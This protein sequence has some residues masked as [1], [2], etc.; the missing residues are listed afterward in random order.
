MFNKG[1]KV[2]LNKKVITMESLLNS[3]LTKDQMK[4]VLENMDKTLTIESVKSSFNRYDYKLVEIDDIMFYDYELLSEIEVV[5]NKLIMTMNVKPVFTISTKSNLPE[6]VSL[7]DKEIE[8]SHQIFRFYQTKK[9]ITCVLTDK[10]GNK[11]VGIAKCNPIDDFDA[12]IGIQ[13]SEL[14]ARE[15]YMHNIVYNFEEEV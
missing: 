3:N 15:D 10:N 9:T 14:R 6:F 5:K 12:N 7:P 13:L 4:E 11:G 8:M 2:V 1:D